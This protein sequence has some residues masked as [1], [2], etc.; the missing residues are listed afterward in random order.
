MDK[1]ELEKLWAKREVMFAKAKWEL[2][3]AETLRTRN[4]TYEEVQ[5]RKDKLTELAGNF[6]GIQ[7]T[8]EES[9][10]NLEDVASV[11]NY[12]LQFDEVYFKA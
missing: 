9:T 5:E 2:S 4:P 10:S 6:D 1:S 12:R 11:F 7:T 8:I 3:V